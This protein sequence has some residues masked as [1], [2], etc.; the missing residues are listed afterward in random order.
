MHRGN[1]P[2]PAPAGNAA[3]HF[4]GGKRRVEAG[5]RT[6]RRGCAATERCRT[7]FVAEEKSIAIEVGAGAGVKMTADPN[8]APPGRGESGGQCREIHAGRRQG[9]PVRG[10]PGRSRVHHGARH[11]G[12]HSRRGTGENLGATLPG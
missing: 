8:A 6:S 2:D 12:R 5:T 10:S 9:V 11:R 7:L 4:G 1:G 3:R